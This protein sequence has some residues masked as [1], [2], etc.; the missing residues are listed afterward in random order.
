MD[1]LGFFLFWAI[2][3]KTVLNVERLGGSISWVSD[4]GSGHDLR[5]LGFESH[6]RVCADSLEPGNC[7]GFCVSLS[8]YPSATHTLSLSVSQK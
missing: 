8:L 7:F 3:N 2:T 1:I 6:I 5:V 4:F